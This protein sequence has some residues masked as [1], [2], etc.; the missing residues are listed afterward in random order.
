MNPIRVI[1]FIDGFN[2]C[3]AID[4]KKL[5]QGGAWFQHPSRAPEVF[6]DSFRWLRRPGRLTTG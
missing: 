6:G 4:K 5:K 2:L 3:H 1:A